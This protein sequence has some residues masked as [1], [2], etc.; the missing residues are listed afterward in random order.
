[1]T[2]PNDIQ[3]IRRFNRYYTQTIGALDEH[4]LKS[5][6]SLT[7]LRILHELSQTAGITAKALAERLAMDH[8]FLSRKLAGLER[9][10]C[11]RRQ[12]SSEDKR[13]QHLYLTAQAEAEQPAL[14]QAADN[15]VAN[16]L[17]DI[18]PERREQLVNAM[19]TVERI[20]TNA[21]PSPVI[22]RQLQGGDAGW[23]I[24][25]HGGAIAQEFGWN[26]E[27]D[28]LCS[29]IMADFIRNYRPDD[30][31]SWIVERDG[32]ILGS[33]FL[34][35]ENETTARLRLLYVEKAARGM[36]LATKLLEKS[37]QFARN[38]GYQTVILFTTD[39]NESA[40]RIY[41]RLGMKLVKEEPFA[42]AGQQ[43]TGE[44]WEIA[45][46]A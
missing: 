1:M 18:A 25:R 36:G 39:S 13:Q 23:I 28:A 40:R 43:Q 34:I 2:E 22:F 42:F 37:F 6:Y 27:F 8:G 14:E 29:Q 17:A 21:P 10:Q 33:L 16:L 20:L 46:N 5:P 19:Q 35:R 38:K 9:K 30:E 32:E 44:T 4:Y 11:I 15:K 24:H 31:R 41:A 12:Q 7:E 26:M 45:L 3:A